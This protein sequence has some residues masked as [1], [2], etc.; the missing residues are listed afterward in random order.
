MKIKSLIV[1][2]GMFSGTV[3]ADGYQWQV[4]GDYLTADDADA[5][6]IQGRYHFDSVSI[7]NTAWAEAAFT[8][9]NSNVGLG[10]SDFDGDF[11]VTSV[12]GEYMGENN[13]YAS[14]GY[15]DSDISGADSVITGEIGYFF[16][17]NWLVAI[18]TDDS[19]ASPVTLRTKYV[20][21]LSNNRFFNVEAS[22]DDESEDLLVEG[23]YY[24]SPQSSVG[25]A[26]SDAE[27]YDFGVRFQHF[28][29]PSISLRLSYQALDGDDV[30]GIGFTARF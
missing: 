20:G 25:L 2:L 16:A 26:L 10:Y 28:F 7:N 22:Y 21:E 5:Y 1:A 17:K 11:S 8:G 23:D 12:F 15:A 14:L 4:D 29:N 13:L 18:G 6:M 30:T 19:D 9:R 3:L 24:W 27:G